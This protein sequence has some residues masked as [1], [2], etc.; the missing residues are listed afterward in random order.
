MSYRLF[1]L[2]L[3][4]KIK[5]NKKEKIVITG[6]L[7]NLGLWITEYL[8]AIGFE[9][10]VL[11]TRN[12]L[13][14]ILINQDFSLI[15]CDIRDFNTLKK[16]IPKDIDY[17]IHLASINDF[18]LPNY[19]QTAIEINSLGTRN[20]LEVVKNL[21]LKRFIYFSTFH[22]YGM[23]S[24]KINETLKPQ[25]KN[26]YALTH[27]FAEYYI[28]QFHHLYNLPYTIFRLTNSYGVPKDINSSKWYLVLN[29]LS[30]MAFEQK[31]IVLKS[32]GLVKRDFISMFDVCRVVEKSLNFQENGTYNLGFGESL[33]IIEIANYVK[34]VYQQMFQQELSITLNHE[35]KT[36]PQKLQVDISKLQ[37]LI[38]YQFQHRF[39]VEIQSI[40]KLLQN[41]S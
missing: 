16:S 22:V 2:L 30:K 28:E 21:N 17:I 9:I 13:N 41:H 25:P 3:R 15:E 19:F 34:E 6:G 38:N 4:K 7:G 32:N 1:T 31:K 26:D 8:S 20:L 5:M 39:E 40:F 33:S 23:S 29:D 18:F 37:Q 24:G 35:D 10:Y 36:E 14:S 11:T 27:L 12:N